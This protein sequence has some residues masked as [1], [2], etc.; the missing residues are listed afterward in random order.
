VALVINAR[1]GLSSRRDGSP[2]KRVVSLPGARGVSRHRS[3]RRGHRARRRRDRGRGRR[4]E[5]CDG[6]RGGRRGD[7]LAPRRGHPHRR[8]HVAP[9]GARVLRRP[10]GAGRR[11]LDPRVAR[12]VHHPPRGRPHLARLATHRRAPGA[13]HGR[14]SRARSAPRA[15]PAHRPRPRPRRPRR[16]V[17]RDAPRLRPDGRRPRRDGRGPARRGPRC[18]GRGRLRRGR[19]DPLDHRA[20]RCAGGLPVL[21]PAGA[22]RPRSQPVARERGA[23][24]RRRAGDRRRD[25]R[26]RP[27]RR[28][29]RR[30]AVEPR[31]IPPARGRAT[32]PRATAR[33]GGRRRGRGYWR[34][35]AGP[36]RARDIA[37][38]RRPHRVVAGLATLQL[39]RAVAG[40]SP[41]AGCRS[42]PSP[43]TRSGCSTAGTACG[44]FRCGRCSTGTCAGRGRARRQRRWGRP[45]G[46]GS[47]A[48]VPCP[49][50]SARRRETP[51]RVD[52]LEHRAR[53]DVVVVRARQQNPPRVGEPPRERGAH[54]GGDEVVVG[55]V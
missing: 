20:R 32:P 8:H 12:V 10:R 16:R 48:G 42:S 26:A 38:R 30:R 52:D 54:R 21:H 13:F 39:R 17:P 4:A 15:R 19:M 55:S 33:R 18:R 35:D 27:G 43:P 36:R 49:D 45:C 46:C 28:R 5:R 50:A 37:P 1:V 24:A 22:L 7:A 47:S 14:A 34:R 51:Q 6:G 41:T 40:G 11:R 9:G 2:P 29:R 31:A 44:W 23:V 53:E 25:R 3:S